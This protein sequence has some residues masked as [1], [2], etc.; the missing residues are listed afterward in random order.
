MAILLA[1]P[2]DAEAR[3]MLEAL[4][5]EGFECE[6]VATGIAAL[7]RAPACEA[8]VAE[9]ALPGLPG[10]ELVRRLRNSGITTPLIFVTALCDPEHRVRG[11]EAGG[12]DYLGRPFAMAELVARLRA[13]IRRSRM[14]PRPRQV[15][16]ADLVWEPDHRRVT[17][18]GRRLD[19]TPKEYALLTLL[20]ARPGQVVSRDEMAL[21]LWSGGRQRPE[22]RSPNALDAQ[23][24]RLRAKVDGPFPVPL[25]QTVRGQG[26]MI[27]S[28]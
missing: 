1:E 22:L 12:D 17:R 9:I 24:R 10:L 28:R 7:D 20:L 2:D 4:A 18:G 26:L 5:A 3:R 23:V 16:L 14:P 25:L 13:L 6:R 19:L 8:L 27:E 11:L 15:G 21:A